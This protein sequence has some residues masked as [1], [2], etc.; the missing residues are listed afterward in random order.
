VWASSDDIELAQQSLD[1]LVGRGLSIV[2]A[3]D[4]VGRE[5]ELSAAKQ[6]LF[7]SRSSFG[8]PLRT[9]C[10]KPMTV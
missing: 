6:R 2:D 8:E 5:F 1:Y 3:A 4:A 9:A 10:C 7:V